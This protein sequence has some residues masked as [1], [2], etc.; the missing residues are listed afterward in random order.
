MRS[1]A[2]S[3]VSV[4]VLAVLIAVGACKKDDETSGGTTVDDSGT[5]QS[6]LTIGVTLSLTGDLEG[7]GKPLRDAIRVA[8]GEINAV[9]GVNGQKV[10]FKIVD[11]QTIAAQ[12][13]TNADAFVKQGVAA[14][15]GPIASSQALAIEKTMRDSKTLFLSPTATSP[16]L[17]KIESTADRWFFR[18]V[19][20]DDFQGKALAKFALTGPMAGNSCKNMAIIHNDDAYGTSFRDVV[21]TAFE[22]GGGKVVTTIGVGAD[23]TAS[24]K[25]QIGDL[26]KATPLV[27]CAALVVF[28]KVGGQF[29]RDFR[30]TTSADASRDWTKFFIMG[31]DGIYTDDFLVESRENKSDPKSNNAA[32]GVYGTIADTAPKTPEYNAFKTNYVSNFPLAAGKTEPDPYTANMYDAAVLLALAIQKAGGA[33]DHLKLRDALISVSKTGKTYGPGQLAEAFGAIKSG[34]DIDYKGASGNVDFDENG[35]VLSDY[36][37]WQVQK[38]ADGTFGFVTHSSVKAEDLQ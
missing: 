8:E 34:Q 31:T 14:M 10:E 3:S 19:P 15:L 4:G 29:M 21:K 11:D 1:F 17:T 7:I 20:P 2:R 36:V 37:V 27:E 16:D 25:T 24:Y 18:T 28:P 9:G 12:V 5:T 22:A 38:N 26:I 35:N 6:T 32:Q 23:V 13:Q 30:S 33:T